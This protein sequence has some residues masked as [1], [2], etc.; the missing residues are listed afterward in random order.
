MTPQ[1]YQAQLLALQRRRQI[2]EALIAQGNEPM[3]GTQMAGRIAIARSPLEGIAK[4][5]A[6]YFGGRANRR[7]E[8]SESELNKRRAAEIATAMTALQNPGQPQ[9]DVPPW[10]AN[11]NPSAAAGPSQADAAAT[12]LGPEQV[13]AMQ[14][15]PKKIDRVDLGDRI[16][17]Y[18][19]GKL[20]GFEEKGASPDAAANREAAKLEHETARADRARENELTRQNTADIAAANRENTAAIAEANRNAAAARRTTLT[21]TQLANVK[22]KLVTVSLL[23][24]QLNNLREKW[25]AI[26]GTYSAGPGAEKYTYTPGGQAFDKA[27]EALQTTIRMLTRT[28]G[29]GSMSDWEGKI[30]Q[31]QV[32][33]RNGFESSTEQQMDQLDDL[34]NVIEKGY[35]DMVSGD[36]MSTE[37]LPNTHGGHAPSTPGIPTFA[38]E[39]DAN[40]AA[41]AGKIKKDDRIVV[42]GIEGTWQ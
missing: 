14:L 34:S 5:G 33:N 8:Q 17:V 6:S 35:K 39:A 20:T 21:G 29:E 11:R 9:T 41:A 40:A 19:D 3:G 2:A 16:G 27:K 23:R 7:V 22:G 38:T 25:K 18:E 24:T 32:P 36:E 10:V 13:A 42:N 30:A 12:I 1:E 4:L 31:A 28:A 15:R 26:K 37:A